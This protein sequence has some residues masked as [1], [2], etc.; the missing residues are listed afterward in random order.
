MGNTETAVAAYERAA[1]I[2]PTDEGIKL[3]L[4]LLKN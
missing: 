4:K 2:D 1:N 3:R